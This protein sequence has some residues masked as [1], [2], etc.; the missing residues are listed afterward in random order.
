MSYE[1]FA[2]RYI[3]S[4]Y[5]VAVYRGEYFVKA[6]AAQFKL[7]RQNIQIKLRYTVGIGKIEYFRRVS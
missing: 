6:D 4:R 1:D 2:A 3:Y 7:A 5:Y